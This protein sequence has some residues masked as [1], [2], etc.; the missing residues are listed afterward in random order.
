MAINN[1]DSVCS[2][3]VHFTSC[4][5]RVRNVHAVHN[6]YCIRNYWPITAAYLTVTRMSLRADGKS[7]RLGVN[8]NTDGLTSPF[9]KQHL[10]VSI[11]EPRIRHT[12]TPSTSMSSSLSS[13]FLLTS[14]AE[15]NTSS[16]S[17][18]LVASCVVPTSSL[19]ASG[20]SFEVS[21]ECGVKYNKLLFS[22]HGFSEKYTWQTGNYLPS[23]C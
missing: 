6:M 20:V 3:E 14:S 22:F 18:P 13:G 10:L 11:L 19:L 5:F 4:R 17:D 9:T 23:L 8:I 21:Y 12:S 16:V 1:H 2:D 7:S 15:D